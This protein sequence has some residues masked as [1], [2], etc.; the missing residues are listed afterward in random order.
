MSVTN[1]SARAFNKLAQSGNRLARWAHA[2]FNSGDDVECELCGW[3]GG[4]FYNGRC[5][6]C[7]SR[8]RTRLVPYAM[9][10]FG[11]DSRDKVLFHLGPNKPETDWIGRHMK[12]RLHIIADILRF[13]IT[14]LICDATKMPLPD[15]SVDLI[16]TWHVLE[17]IPNDRVV[18]REMLR[19]L[20]PNAKVLMSVPIVPPHRAQTFEDKTVPREKY[21]EVYG[22]EDHVRACGLDYGHRFVDEGF[23]MQQLRVLDLMHTSR[24]NDVKF[25]GL[26]A[27]HVVWCFQKG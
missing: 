15:D 6:V 26:S 17:H 9:R 11:L 7:N 18:V 16:I 12:P 10:H 23:I 21:I 24:K 3:K 20:R 19:V 27:N 2:R 8:P 14:T 1:L 22:H 25:K 13:P 5:P 4:S